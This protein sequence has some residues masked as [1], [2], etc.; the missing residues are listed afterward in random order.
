MQS[1]RDGIFLKIAIGHQHYGQHR[2]R[3]CDLIGAHGGLGEVRER[4]RRVIPLGEIAEQ[5]RSILDTVRPLDAWPPAGGVGQVPGDQVDG[6][7]IAEGV[8]DRHRR[9]LRADGSVQEY[10]QRFALDLRVAM[11]HRDRRFFVAARKQLGIAV[12]AVVDHRFVQRT[13]ARSRVGAN[14][15]DADRLQNVDHEVGARMLGGHDFDGRWRAGL[16]LARGSG[17]FGGGPRCGLLRLGF[18]WSS[19]ERCRS[20]CGTLQEFAAIY[21]HPQILRQKVVRGGLAFGTGMN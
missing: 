3:H 1:V 6:N 5:R 17:R 16:G 4:S 20:R 11:R 7:A 13:E 12:A 9:V 14:V 21:S 2:R 18:S 10:G 8:V 19:R 15:L